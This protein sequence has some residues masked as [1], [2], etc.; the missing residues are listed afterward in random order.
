MEK[1]LE[2]YYDIAAIL[3]MDE[4]PDIRAALDFRN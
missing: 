3:G 2:I 4:N 1:T